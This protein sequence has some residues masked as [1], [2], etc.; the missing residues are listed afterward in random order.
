MIDRARVARWIIGRRPKRTLIR[1]LV[2]GLV[3]AAVCKWFVRPAWID[4][5]SMEPTIRDHG[6][7]FLSLRAYLR[8]APERHDI[9]AIRGV[10]DRV[11]LLKRVVGLPGETVAFEN[12]RVH[13]NGEP[14][15][16]PYAEFRGNWTLPAFEVPGEMYFVVGD[17]RAMASHLHVMGGVDV[18]AIYGRLIW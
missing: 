5:Q 13:I 11:F 6:L 7:H 4:G 16:E 15:D 9:V 10:G 12:G 3:L 8:E 18:S 2:I 17:N 14:L 1:A